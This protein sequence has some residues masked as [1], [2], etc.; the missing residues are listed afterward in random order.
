MFYECRDLTNLNLSNFNTQNVIDMN[1][2]FC[3]CNSLVNIN[4]GD[5]KKVYFNIKLNMKILFYYY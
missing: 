3:G 5:D 4:S 1:D 2:M